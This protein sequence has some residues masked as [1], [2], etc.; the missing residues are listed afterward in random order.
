MG[1]HDARPSR[2]WCYAGRRDDDRAFGPSFGNGVGLAMAEAH[3]AASYIAPSFEI[4]N[5][6]TYGIV[7]DGD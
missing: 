7:S 6:F 5:H 3:L 1:Q 2:A 4:V